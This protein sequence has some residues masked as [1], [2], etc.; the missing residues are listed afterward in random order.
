MTDKPGR[1]LVPSSGGV[2]HDILLR[3]KL[4]LRLMLDRRVSLF[5]K[6]LPLGSLVYLFVPDFLPGPVDDAAMIA[7]LSYL[8]VEL[9]PEQVVQEH[10]RALTSVVDA[11]WREVDEEEERK[12]I[13][14]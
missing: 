12:Q 14:D 10:M 7:L 3:I 5:L 6:L 8:F 13:R 9:C 1:D 2:F 4:I 11:D